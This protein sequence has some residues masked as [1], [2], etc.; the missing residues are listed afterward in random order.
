MQ[1]T[2]ETLRARVLNPTSVYAVHALASTQARRERQ[3]TFTV[4]S[5]S[6]RTTLIHHLPLCC[7]LHR[8]GWTISLE[9]DMRREGEVIMRRTAEQKRRAEEEK[10]S[11]SLGLRPS[12]HQ[13]FP[14]R[15]ITIAVA[16]NAIL[17]I[18]HRIPLAPFLSGIAPLLSFLLRPIGHTLSR[19][20]L[21]LT[22]P[23][24]PRKPKP[25]QDSDAAQDAATV[26]ARKW[27]EW[28]D[29]HPTG[30]GNRMG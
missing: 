7:V 15:H 20:F 10:R 11:A 28:K 17:P 9:D 26:E 18:S 21:P 3:G 6:S 22:L 16:S 23:S 27:D 5:Y 4:S 8:P 2:R 30:S 1:I 29:D 25:D 12:A 24:S 13:A 14:S 19:P